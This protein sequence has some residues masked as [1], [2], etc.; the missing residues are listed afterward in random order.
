MEQIDP[1]TQLAHVV[2]FLD[3]LRVDSRLLTSA[4]YRNSIWSGS[5]DTTA[6]EHLPGYLALLYERWLP[7]IRGAIPERN[8]D[9]L[10]RRYSLDGQKHALLKEL[11]EKYGVGNERI[12]QLELLGL[13][14]L[15]KGGQR[16]ELLQI[17]LDVVDVIKSS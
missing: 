14:Y 10:I 8:A 9:I 17:A 6:D 15:R 5:T 1:H 16:D 12:R 2:R 13:N 4:L 3:D 11:A 7:V